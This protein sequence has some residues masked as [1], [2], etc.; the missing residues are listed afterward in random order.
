MYIKRVDNISIFRDFGERN[1][2]RVEGTLITEDFYGRKQI[3]KFQTDTHTWA[4]TFASFN[5]RWVFK[6]KVRF[7]VCGCWRIVVRI[8][9]ANS[10]MI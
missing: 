6:L 10:I 1:D 2:V 7:F 9:Q 4:N 8:L 5:W 3:R